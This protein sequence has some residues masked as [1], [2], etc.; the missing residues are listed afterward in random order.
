M[1]EN[2]KWFLLQPDALAPALE[3]PH[4]QVNFKFAKAGDSTI[5]FLVRHY[6]GPPLDWMMPW[7][8]AICIR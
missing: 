6:S 4:A 8:P 3:N 2:L 5:E 1:S 7:T